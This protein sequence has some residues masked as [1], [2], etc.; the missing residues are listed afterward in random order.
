MWSDE[1]VSVME[2]PWP[3]LSRNLCGITEENHLKFQLGYIV[4]DARFEPG[5]LAS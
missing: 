3:N 4:S 1:M 2:R 5:L